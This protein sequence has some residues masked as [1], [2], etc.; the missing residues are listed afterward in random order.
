MW[1]DFSPNHSSWNVHGCDLSNVWDI[2]HIRCVGIYIYMYVCFLYHLKSPVILCIVLKFND[3]WTNRYGSK[4][5][6]SVLFWIYE[7]LF[8]Q[9]LFWHIYTHI[10]SI[11]QIWCDP[12]VWDWKCFFYSFFIISSTISI[13]ICVKSRIFSS[14]TWI[15]EFITLWKMALHFNLK[16]YFM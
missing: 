6:W 7:F 4:S 10:F 13:T 11:L 14:L 2:R 12:K 16:N 3:K 15:S 1:Q 5:P 8:W 9:V